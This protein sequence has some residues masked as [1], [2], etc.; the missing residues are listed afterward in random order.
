MKRKIPVI[1]LIALV[2]VAVFGSQTLADKTED[3]P[4][5]PKLLEMLHTINDSLEDVQLD[6]NDVLLFRDTIENTDELAK[7]IDDTVKDIRT[8]VDSI[9]DDTAE[10]AHT[11]TTLNTTLGNVT[12][13]DTLSGHAEVKNKYEED[14]LVEGYP[15]IR[16]VSLT[17]NAL[18]LDHSDPLPDD[19][20]IGMIFGIH[21]GA[22]DVVT[23]NGVRTYEFD[24]DNWY[25]RVSDSGNHS[26]N[27]WYHATITYPS[28]QEQSCV[29]EGH[30][31]TE[32]TTPLLPI[33][34]LGKYL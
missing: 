24:T 23:T 18:G 10:I 25:L 17:F 30:K 7:G 12:M 29:R 3:V 33:V 26:V 1:A 9:L 20:S 11:V 6:M 15:G 22:L 32:M 21:P 13:M 34:M 31:M 2:A 16:H 4:S 27:V 28:N 5:Q 8:G 19:V 14:I